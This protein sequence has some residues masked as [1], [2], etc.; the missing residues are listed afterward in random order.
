MSLLNSQLKNVRWF[1]EFW[2][3][4]RHLRFKLFKEMHIY[5][6]IQWASTL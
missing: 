2:L 4:N 5:V 6:H 1:S 3:K